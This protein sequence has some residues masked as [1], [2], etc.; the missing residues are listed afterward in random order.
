MRPQHLGRYEISAELGQ[1]GMGTVYQATD[2][3]FQREVAV[4]ILP[5]RLLNDPGFRESFQREAQTIAA[6]EHIAIVPVYDFGEE[7]GQP[8]LVMKLMAGGTLSAIVA[9]RGPLPLDETEAI[10]SRLAAGL[11]KAHQAGILH[12]DL[13]PDNILFD[14]DGSPAIADFGLA[15]I[16]T[17]SA[18]RNDNE[19]VVGTLAYMS[20]EQIL[21]EGDF[22]GRADIYALGIILFEMLTGEHPFPVDNHL[23]YLQAHIN[24]PVPSPLTINSELPAGLDAV[25]QRAM[26]KFREDRYS[27][28]GEL[29]ADLRDAIGD[30]QADARHNLPT[31]ATPFIGRKAE[32]AELEEM[33]A[34]DGCK[35]ITLLGSGGSGKT[36]LSLEV[37]NQQLSNHANGV[38]FVS[39][40]PLEQAQ[41]IVYAIA[42]AVGFQF[43][44]GRQPQQQLMDYF[45]EKNLLLVMDNFEHVIDGARLVGELL[46]HAP[47]LRVIATSRQRLNLAAECV[48]D[49][50]GME[51]PADADAQIFEN[52][53]AVELFVSYAQRVQPDYVLYAAHRAAIADICTLVDGLPLG[54]ELAAAWVRS[55][56]PDSIAEELASDI[57]LLETSRPD[58]PDRQR[59]MQAVFDYSWRLLSD[60]EQ[61]ALMRFSVFR[62]GATREAI[63][64][65]TGA[66]LRTLTALV[67]QSL[68]RHDTAYGR[69]TIHEL[70]RQMAAAQLDD[71]GETT[72]VYDAHCDFYLRY[73]ADCE[74]GLY[75]SEQ[76]ESREAIER[77]IDNVLAA[78]R[79][80]V[81]HQHDAVLDAALDA[82]TLYYW[83]SG[84]TQEGQSLYRWTAEMLRERGGQTPTELL[85]RVILRQADLSRWV[86]GLRDELTT[87]LEESLT[88]AQQ[89]GDRREEALAYLWLGYIQLDVYYAES[90]PELAREF[91]K[92]AETIFE[93]LDDRWGI[94]H[95]IHTRGVA[96]YTNLADLIV[97]SREALAIRQEIGDLYGA[98]HSL[99]NL[100]L[101]LAQSGQY[102]EGRAYLEQ[103][104][105]TLEALGRGHDDMIRPLGNVSWMTSIT[106]DDKESA[107]RAELCRIYAI[108][109]GDPYDVAWSHLMIGF[110]QLHPG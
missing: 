26:A 2:P 38:Y 49:V 89:S 61:H 57:S 59:S 18:R 46:E 37:A 20:P 95:V 105:E 67:D 93:A 80:A 4:K 99:N 100:G 76:R 14:A 94:A 12:R 11:D 6:L 102:A 42:D 63:R 29:A 98:S 78:W 51:A 34:D 32:L 41:H 36:R 24:E 16:L 107:R 91:L 7:G 19:D 65:V 28:A 25:V 101:A 74:A 108:E 43:S 66:S 64:G 84:Q 50:R 62:G 75:V 82:M 35:L 73:V 47:G 53:E 54:I 10:I 70:V 110:E 48:Y 17:D 96:A 56:T 5:P 81:T 104:L 88:I 9:R 8:Y 87:L 69:Y 15:K 27:T 86:S 97:H 31:P 71:A 39:L 33:L 13:K 1:G 109:R 79:W 85:G 92:K 3:A 22:D 68:L 30:R 55:L 21:G 103:C 23:D 58:V 83:Q 72:R 60:D 44:G 77:E 52:F 45:R 90:R 40:A 106:G